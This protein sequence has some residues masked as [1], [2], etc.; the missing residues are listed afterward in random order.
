VC[1][2]LSLPRGANSIPCS[3]FVGF[4][5]SF[6]VVGRL[7]WL[8]IV[9]VVAVGGVERNHTAVAIPGGFEAAVI[10]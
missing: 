5:A 1:S 9:A 10:N 2:S 4:G 7:F 3:L 6:V 8:L